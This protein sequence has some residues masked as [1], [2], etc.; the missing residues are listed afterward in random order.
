MKRPRPL[1]SSLIVDDEEALMTALVQ[2][3]WSWKATP[4]PASPSARKALEC[5]PQH[6]FELLLTDLMMPEMD[7][8]HFCAARSRSIPDLAGIVMKGHGTIDKA[9]RA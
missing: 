1:R 5:L 6:E 7:G 8:M 3:P 2:E 4:R 9:S